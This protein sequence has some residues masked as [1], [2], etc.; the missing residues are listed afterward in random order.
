MRSETRLSVGQR[1]RRRIT[2]FVLLATASCTV[3][4]INFP[5][6]D[7]YKKGSAP[8]PAESIYNP[9]PIVVSEVRPSSDIPPT[10]EVDCANSN[11]ITEFKP[12]STVR[13]LGG[14]DGAIV[15]LTPTGNTRNALLVN[16]DEGTSER[17]NLSDNPDQ[18]SMII[19]EGARMMQVSAIG[20]PDAIPKIQCAAVSELKKIADEFIRAEISKGGTVYL[21]TV[22]QNGALSQDPRGYA[23]FV[24]ANRA[25]D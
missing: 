15:T 14:P 11:Q 6:V 4:D 17:T 16:T 2:P 3:G 9:P 24:P 10:E 25:R 20:D 22:A 13:I 19:S 8:I 7:P 21:H 1:L 23:I 12:G 5:R 18:A